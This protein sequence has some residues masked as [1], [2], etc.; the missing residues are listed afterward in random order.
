MEL[1]PSIEWFVSPGSHFLLIIRQTYFPQ[2][3]TS[4]AGNSPGSK[5]SNGDMVL[6]EGT[7]N[8]FISGLYDTISTNCTVT[9]VEPD[10]LICWMYTRT[11]QTTHSRCVCVRET[12]THTHILCAVGYDTVCGAGQNFKLK[13]YEKADTYRCLGVSLSG[14]AMTGCV[15]CWRNLIMTE[16]MTD[17]TEPEGEW[18]RQKQLN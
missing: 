15:W 6:L 13:A 17:Y 12:H 2:Q 14:H 8:L 1:N 16:Q 4:W 3:K 9:S 11:L 10:Q 7:F 5:V 18:V